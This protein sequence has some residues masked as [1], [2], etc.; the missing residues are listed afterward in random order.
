MALSKKYFL[1]IALTSFFNCLPA[2]EEKIAIDPAS[3]IQ[4]TSRW[5]PAYLMQRGD[6]KEAIDLYLEAYRRD[7]SHDFEL[8]EQIALILLEHGARSSD[9]QRQLISIFGARLAGV[10]SPLDLLE[11]G[12]KSRAPETQLTCVQT[13]AS[14][15]DDRCDEALLSA[16]SSEFFPV[17]MEAGFHLAQRKHP[18]AAGQ[19]EALMHQVPPFMKFLFPD[20]FATLGTKE[21]LFIL[22][23]LMTDNEF[24]CRVEAILS[25]ARH[26]RDDLLPAIRTRASH[27]NAPEQEACATALGLLHDS[28]SLPRLKKLSEVPSNCVRLAALRSLLEMGQTH[29]KDTIAALV[30]TGDYFAVSLA[31]ELGLAREEVA[32]LLQDPDHQMRMNA[33]IALLSMHDARAAPALLDIFLSDS[34]GLGIVPGYS[35]GRSLIAWKIVPSIDQQKKDFYDMAAVSLAVREHML[36]ETVELEEKAFLSIARAIF[37]HGQTDL[38]PLLVS[39][40]E[41]ARTPAA[42]LLLQEQANKAGAPLIRAY[43]TLALFRM[44]LGKNEYEDGIKQWLS[45]HRKTDMIRFRP[46]LPLGMRP[47]SSPYELTAE[48]KSRLLV[49]ICQAL[50]D[51]H[52]DKSLLLLIEAIRDGRSENRYALAGL[53]LRALQ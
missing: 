8:L 46:S 34:R 13:L 44:N 3:T 41:N 5:Q 32:S 23:Q 37:K 10:A 6:Y 2:D 21:A 36:R 12:L 42:I 15:Q 17:R 11:A 50:A 27:L 9:P 39:L 29:V 18:K 28:A 40:L 31:G 24:N 52:D 51:R 4:S 7:S 25:A 1:T 33:A 47:F 48:E 38:I 49:E 30:K 22:R 14:L 19:I 45:S 26:N 53:L 43:C 16:M 35:P 20:F